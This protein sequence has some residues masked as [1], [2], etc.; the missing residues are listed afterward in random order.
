MNT[1]GSGGHRSGIP[2]ESLGF[3]GCLFPVHTK[4]EL[5]ALIILNPFNVAFSE[6]IYW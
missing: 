1:A 4:F 2:I 3:L 5:L 6:L